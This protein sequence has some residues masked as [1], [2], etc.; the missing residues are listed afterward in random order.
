MFFRVHYLLKVRLNICNETVYNR[1]DVN[2]VTRQ[3]HYLYQ[4]SPYQ[5]SAFFFL[6]EMQVTRINTLSFSSSCYQ[7][8]QVLRLRKTL[9]DL[10]KKKNK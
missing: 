7:A 2:T 3:V 10:K 4:L 1:E 8:S 9:L 6:P 5:V